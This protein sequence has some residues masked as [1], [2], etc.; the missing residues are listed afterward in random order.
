V[1][2]I[3][4]SLAAAF[5]RFKVVKT[6]IG[7]SSPPTLKKG[8]ALGLLDA[9]FGYD[10][11]ADGVKGVDLVILGTPIHKILE[12]L[13]GIMQAAGPGT[14]VTD[15]GST[16][17][18][19][20]EKASDVATDQVHFIGGHPMAGSEKNGITAADP[21]LF[22][23]AI[24]VLTPSGSVPPEVIE[25]LKSLLDAVGAK[26]TILEPGIHDQIAAS[27]SHLPQMLAVSL[28]NFIHQVSGD[29]PT[30]LKLAAG[31]FRDMTRIASSPYTMWHDICS[32]NR[33]LIQ[34]KIDEFTACL[35]A[36]K[37]R[38]GQE[39]LKEDF[40]TAN[41][42]RNAI[43]RDTKGF[44]YPHPE[45]LVVT[46]DKPGMLAKITTALGENR[47]N[48]NDIEVLKVREGEGGTIRLSVKDTEAAQAAVKILNETGFEAR[49]RG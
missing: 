14:I 25:K 41:R 24:Y 29:D 34:R 31:G 38:I 33:D 46:E 35:E 26:V 22:E 6:I 3:G 1:G 17:R 21:F 27:V 36:L 42:T 10:Q 18:V 49:I 9:G 15:V 7:I 48:I 19:I 47:I 28:V 5:R 37:R 43:P 39:Q 16:K 45:V 12:M 13:P 11:L 4:G 44:L 23:N 32:T 8:K 30:Y 20:M 40:S 2:L